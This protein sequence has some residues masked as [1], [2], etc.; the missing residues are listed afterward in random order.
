LTDYFNCA[1]IDTRD[2]GPPFLGPFPL[3][4]GMRLKGPLSVLAKSATLCYTWYVGR[5]VICDICKKEIELRWGIFAHDT[6]S[7]HRREHK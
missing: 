5:V 1:I 2:V 3:L 6:L 7:R 4:L